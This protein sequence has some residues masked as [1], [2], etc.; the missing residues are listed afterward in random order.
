MNKLLQELYHGRIP[1][2]DSQVHTTPTDETRERI[3]SERRY[4]TSKMSDKDL[5]RYKKM[6]ALYAECHARRYENVYINA[7]KLGV[8]LMCAVFTDGNDKGVL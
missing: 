4:F 2:W 5:E 1:G 7:F 6:E 3:L 8:L